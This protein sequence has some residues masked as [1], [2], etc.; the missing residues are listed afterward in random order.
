MVKGGGRDGGCNS[1]GHS[2]GGAGGDHGEDSP[3]HYSKSLML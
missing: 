3:S 1:C 2:A